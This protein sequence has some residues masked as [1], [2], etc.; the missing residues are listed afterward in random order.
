MDPEHVEECNIFTNNPN[1]HWTD[2]AILANKSRV[3]DLE[4]QVKQKMGHYFD[5]SESMIGAS[6]EHSKHL[7]NAGSH[8]SKEGSSLL[9]IESPKIRKSIESQERIDSVM[10]KRP[11]GTGDSQA[12]QPLMNQT[13]S[14]NTPRV[15]TTQGHLSEMNQSD[16]IIQFGPKTMDAIIEAVSES[17][18]LFWEGSI[19]MQVSTQH[20]STNNK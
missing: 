9:G 1:I 16:F 8:L 10:S 5:M 19:S 4:E 7:N 3:V 14:I 15:E 13:K 12:E 2:V 17:F 6:P 18:K 20:S 11:P